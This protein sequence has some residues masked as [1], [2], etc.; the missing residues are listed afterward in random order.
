MTAILRDEAKSAVRQGIKRTAEGRSDVNV[1]LLVTIATQ[2]PALENGRALGIA[3]NAHAALAAGCRCRGRRRGGTASEQTSPLFLYD[4]RRG[5]RGG[6]HRR[7]GGIPRLAKERGQGDDEG[8]H[9]KF[10][11]K[12]H[13]KTEKPST[14]M[15]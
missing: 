15:A 7:G 14:P 6:L 10:L 11:P 12:E 4:H 9:F 8:V 13:Q 3:H 5:S 2:Q 1:P